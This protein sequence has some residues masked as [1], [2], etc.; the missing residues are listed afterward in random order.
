MVKALRQLGDK[1]GDDHDLDVLRQRLTDPE[2]PVGAPAMTDLVLQVIEAKQS[3][4]RAK[5]RQTWSEA[6]ADKPKTFLRR[7]ERHYRAWY[8]LPAGEPLAA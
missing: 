5:C 4:L 7:L 3:R 1:L 2:N 6:L 8:V